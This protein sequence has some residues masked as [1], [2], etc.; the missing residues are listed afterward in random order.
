MVDQGDCVCG[1]PPE[2]CNAAMQ[3]KS[4]ACRLASANLS[5]DNGNL[6]AQHGRVFVHKV[7]QRPEVFLVQEMDCNL[8][9]R[10]RVKCLDDLEAGCKVVS[11]SIIVTMANSQLLANSLFLVGHTTSGQAVNVGVVLFHN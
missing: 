4:S 3:A 6:L 5:S 1:I 11:A 7:H 10:A 8:W 2:R 9:R